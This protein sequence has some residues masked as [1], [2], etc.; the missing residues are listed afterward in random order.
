MT[1]APWDAA[2]REVTGIPGVRGA[3]VISS[4]DGLI[5]AET[6]MDDLATADVAALAAAII[7]R[8]GRATSSVDG[9]APTSVQFVAEGGAIFA[10]AGVVPLWLVAVAR[11]DA[12]LGRLRVLL[13][14][15]AGALG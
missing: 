6:A 10:V 11:P 5:V 14:D 13:R 9:S 12:E 2:M 4:D 15:F 1:A 8:A 7:A 3:L